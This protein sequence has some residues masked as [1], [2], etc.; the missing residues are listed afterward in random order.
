VSQRR[1]A[2]TLEHGGASNRQERP[3]LGLGLALAGIVVMAVGGVVAVQGAE[4]VVDALQISDTA[5]GLTLV[6]LATT[7][8]LLAVAW[9]SCWR[10]RRRRDRG[11]DRLQRHRDPGRR[12]SRSAGQPAS[13][14]GPRP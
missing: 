5:V 1:R 12:R 14:F 8:E 11:V 9:A 2:R 10:A 6:A 7:A 13:T 3:S 4:R